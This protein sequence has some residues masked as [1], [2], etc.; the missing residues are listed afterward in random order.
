MTDVASSNM[1]DEDAFASVAAPLPVPPV[2]V[3]VDDDDAD[4]VAGRGV[5]AVADNINEPGTIGKEFE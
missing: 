3:D 2:V 4:V 1:D 5:T